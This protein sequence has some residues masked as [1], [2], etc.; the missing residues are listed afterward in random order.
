MTDDPV[1]R[2][3]R[4]LAKALDEV[5]SHNASASHVTPKELLESWQRLVDEDHDSGDAEP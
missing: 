1:Q 4:A 3:R 2:L 5:R